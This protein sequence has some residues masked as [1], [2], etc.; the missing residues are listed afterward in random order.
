MPSII[1]KRQ[2]LRNERTLAELVRTVPGN[3]RCADCD[4]L[5]T[6]W[7][8][9]NM[10]IFLC[11][12]CAAIHRKLGTHISKVKSL[13]MDT[14]TDEQ[15][16]SMKSHGNMLMNKIF[17]PKNVKPPVP[18][19]IDEADSCMERFIRQKYQY[20]SLENGKPKP[21]SREEASYSRDQDRRDDRR[22]RQKSY[23]DY[24][25]DDRSPED[26]PPPLPPKSGNW[27]GLRTASS[28]SNLSRFSSKSKASLSPS[29]DQ[30]S[31]SRP[32]RQTT[33]LGAPVADMTTASF[34]AKMAALQDMGFTNDRR[35]EMVLRGLN[36]NLDKSIE[37]LVRLGEGSNPGSRARTP[38]PAERPTASV[39]APAAPRAPSPSPFDMPTARSGNPASQ[40]PQGASYN[41]F[42]QVTAPQ[43][44]QP[45]PSLEASFQTLQVSQP[46]FPHSTGGFPAQTGLMP[47]ATYQQ[48]LT[49]PATS[50][51]SSNGFVSSPQALNS[52]HNPFFQTGATPQGISSA[53]S[54]PHPT[55]NAQPNNPFFNGTSQPQS[56]N[57]YGQPQPQPQY[58]G[59]P[60]P[61]I[62]IPPQPQ[63]ANT[64]PSISST[65]PFGTSPFSTSP[66]SQTPAFQTQPQQPQSQPLRQQTLPAAQANYN[67]FQQPM[68]TQGTFQQNQF[69][70]QSQ[71]Q[72]QQQPQQQQMMPQYTS[73]INKN[74]ILSL[75]NVNSTPTS[76]PNPMSSVPEQPQFQY[77]QANLG[78]SPVPQLSNSLSSTP[79]SL[80][81][82]NMQTPPTGATPASRN[83][84]GAASVG[85][86][87]AA[88]A[89]VNAFATSSGLG[90]GMSSAPGN[91]MKTSP[92][93]FTSPPPASNGFQ[94][95]HMSQ[96]SVDVNGFQS[97]R[98]SPDAFAS[99]SARYG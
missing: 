32:P 1:S 96:P 73:A 30:Q 4:A 13:S 25:R 77:Q 82:S 62:N 19:D 21:P 91:G 6:G 28:T 43:P 66:F 55:S 42:D 63:H 7:A 45:A 87:L 92:S 39:A 57:P 50:T 70:S 49:P 56:Q 61:S 15:V 23:D 10:G 90:I 38:V 65:S 51:F 37:T 83:P 95:T 54:F 76:N 27:F 74:N 46:L 93:P 59:Q 8:S 12:R 29:M 58:N 22:S 48:P 33:G 69:Q 18:T 24:D 68:G 99:L 3:D 97:G 14:W 5:N 20:R 80:S 86:G 40:Q 98:H 81:G 52:N 17:N 72:L 47:Q 34:E 35:N 44:T 41:P 67:P 60:M 16:D 89:G 88:Q 2:Q 94:R 11:M 79:L 78:T 36:E 31:W 26:S 75:Y 53:Q 9:W 64:M 85:S 84:F 71:P